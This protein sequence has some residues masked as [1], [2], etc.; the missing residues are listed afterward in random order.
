MVSVPAAVALTQLPIRVEIYEGALYWLSAVF[1]WW[2]RRHAKTLRSTI[3][4]RISDAASAT[5]P[6]TRREAWGL[7]AFAFLMLFRE[8]AE[9]VLLLGAVSLTTEAMLAF[10]GMVLGLAGSVAFGVMFVKGGLIWR[11]WK[12]LAAPPAP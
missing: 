5:A 3:E 2:V 11:T 12:P 8:G 4:R 7:G 1:V 6:G 9:A 10:A